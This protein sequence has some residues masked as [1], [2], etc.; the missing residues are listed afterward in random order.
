MK[1][2]IKWTLK[3]TT[4]KLLSYLI[5]IAGSVVAIILHDKEVFL[6]SLMYS[7]LLQGVKAVAERFN[8]DK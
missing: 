6:Q 5:F 4:S 7:S 3:F 2:Y 8:D 1:N